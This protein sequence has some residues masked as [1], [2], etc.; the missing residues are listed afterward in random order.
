MSATDTTSDRLETGP[1]RIDLAAWQADPSRWRGKRAVVVEGAF[2][3]TPAVTTWTP[4]VL[5]ERFPTVPVLAKEIPHEAWSDP[6]LARFE[7]M[8][9]ARFVELLR[10]GGPG[11]IAQQPIAPFTG[12]IE[13]VDLE[14]MAEAPYRRVYLWLGRGTR[15]PLHYDKIEN[16]FVQV[17]GT[18]QFVL[19]PP[20]SP[21]KRYM[22]DPPSAH[23]SLVDPYAP[24]RD[25]FPDYDPGQQQ[26][27]LLKAGDALYLPP[28]WFHDVTAPDLSISVNCWYG[29]LLP[30]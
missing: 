16:V 11:Q 7:K 3:D 22:Q 30:E 24:D 28:G 15:T 21:A 12:L 14:R 6:S 20:S 19:E 13:D 29:E 8:D 23:L 10:G 27:V 17:L 9:L 18:K 25:L 4:E 2:A 1:E 26:R 5:A